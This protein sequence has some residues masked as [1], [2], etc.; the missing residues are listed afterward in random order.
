MALGMRSPRIAPH[1]DGGGAGAQPRWKHGGGELGAETGNNTGLPLATNGEPGISFSEF[2]LYRNLV[3]N[4]L[5]PPAGSSAAPEPP[6]HSVT[7]WTS[8]Q[9]VTPIAIPHTAHAPLPASPLIHSDWLEDQ[10]PIGRELPSISP[11]AL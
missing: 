5:R 3:M 7:D 1:K 9:T 10:P 4:P 2:P 6:F 11:R 8:D